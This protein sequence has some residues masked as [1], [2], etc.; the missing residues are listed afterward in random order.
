MLGPLTVA[1]V[2]LTGSG[3][4]TGGRSS[5]SRSGRMSAG[6]LDA[7]RAENNAVSIDGLPALG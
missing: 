3:A 6:E 2:D 7:Y 1:Y 4:E 5:W